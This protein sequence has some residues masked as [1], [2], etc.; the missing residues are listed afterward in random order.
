MAEIADAAGHPDQAAGYRALR[1]KIGA[2]FADAFLA[3]DGQIVSG[4]Q[5]AYILGLHMQLIPE[6]LRAAAAGHLVDAIRRAGWHLSTGFAGVGYLLP[7]LSS[8]GRDDVAYRLL[9]QESWPS[10]RYMLDQGAT[11]IWERW[12]GWSGERGFQSAWMNSFNHYSLGSVAE[13]LYRFLLGIDQAPGAPCGLR[14]AGAAAA[15]RRAAALGAR[16]LPVGA[17]PDQRPRGHWPLETANQLTLPRRTAA[18]CH[19]R[20]CACRAADASRSVRDAMG[21]RPPGVG[22]QLPRCLLGAAQEAAFSHVGPGTSRGSPG[23]TCGPM[24]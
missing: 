3:A 7:V 17:R 10:W 24:R 2:A 22:G 18:E 11:T 20:A 16:L 21:R 12:D 8:V 1:A 15:P 5:T 6:E 13:W 23:L 19:G 14:P 4:T 9:G